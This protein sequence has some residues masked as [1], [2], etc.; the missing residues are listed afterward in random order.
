MFK[1][2]SVVDIEKLLNDEYIFYAHTNNESNIEDETLQ[3]H[4]NR[5]IK[6]FMNIVKQ[7]TTWSV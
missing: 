3:E 6:H 7:R 2:K 5:C 1:K 4:T